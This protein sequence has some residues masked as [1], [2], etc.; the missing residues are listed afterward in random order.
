YNAYILSELLKKKEANDMAETDFIKAI[1]PVAWRHINLYGVYEFHRKA[2][3]IN[4]S[5]IINNLD[6]KSMG[7]HLTEGSRYLN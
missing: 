2:S 4:I 1:S 3:F 7:I 6:E 5:E